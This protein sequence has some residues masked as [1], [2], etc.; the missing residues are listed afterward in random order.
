MARRHA[1]SFDASEPARSLCGLCPMA[2][3]PSGKHPQ[4]PP[5]LIVPLKISIGVAC[6][7][8]VSPGLLWEG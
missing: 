5:D 4:P 7:M 6:I 3:V 1:S 2:I 8:F